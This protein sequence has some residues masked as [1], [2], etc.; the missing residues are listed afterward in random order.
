MTKRP[1]P[2]KT[3]SSGFEQADTAA[4]QGDFFPE[5]LPPAGFNPLLRSHR[6]VVA[7]LLKDKALWREQI[8]QIG[9]VSNG[10]ELMAC[11]GIR[12]VHWYCQRVPTM[13]KLGEPRKAGLYRLT[14]YGRN[15]FAAELADYYSMQKKHGGVM[16]RSAGI[17]FLAVIRLSIGAA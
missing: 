17:T 7:A 13:N 12:D 1:A 4:N 15:I 14:V 3:N 10:P 8:D 16:M 2:K 11:I 9:V 6:D 5:L